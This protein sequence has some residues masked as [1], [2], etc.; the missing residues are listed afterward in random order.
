MLKEQKSKTTHLSPGGFND[1]IH[2][3]SGWAIIIFVVPTAAAGGGAAST[4]APLL[5]PTI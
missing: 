2:I 1:P 4:R 3:H 5:I